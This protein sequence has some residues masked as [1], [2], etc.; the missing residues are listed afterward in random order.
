MRLI[1]IRHGQTDENKEKRYLGHFDSPLNNTGKQQ[2]ESLVER[3]KLLKVK[4]ACYSSDLL[5]AVETSE[6]ICNAY[7][8]ELM[9]NPDLRELHFGDWDCHTYDELNEKY[10]YSL[11]QWI[12]NPFLY[13][14]PNGETLTQLGSRVDRWVEEIIFSKDGEDCLIVSHGGPIR[15]ILSK[16]LFQDEQQFWNVQNIHHGEGIILDVDVTRNI[17]KLVGEVAHM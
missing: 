6:I 5:R 15:W 16:W 2:I 9:V 8:L 17:W 13:A 14:P 7:S 12:S 10:T 11:N 4:G 3:L 1:L